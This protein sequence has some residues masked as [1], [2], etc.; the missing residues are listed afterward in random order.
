M[1]RFQLKSFAG[2][3]ADYQNKG[4]LGCYKTGWNLDI[5]KDTDSLSC[6]QDLVEEGS[7]V[8]ADLIRWIIPCTDGNAYGFGGAGKIY[9]RTSAGVWTL[10]YTDA[11]GA[12]TGAAEWFL[13]S[14]KTYLFWATATKINC[15]EIPGNSGWTD[16]NAL[17]GYPK[18]TL[19]SATWHTMAQAVG[20]L[21]IAND[22]FLAMIGYDG[23]Y[24]YQAL[25]IFKKH[26]AKSLLERGN[27]VIVGTS[28]KDSAG[29][30]DL[31]QW[32]T[33]AL[34]WN[35]RKQIA[36]SSVNALIDTDLPLAQVGSD[37]GIFYSDMQ[38]RLPIVSIP[39]GGYCNP[40]G[41]TCKDGLALFGIYGNSL[42]NNRA[43]S[44]LNGIYSYGRTKLN[45]NRVL[46]LEYNIGTCDEI[47]AL[48]KVG[49]DLLVSYQNGSSY[50]VKKV[51]TAVKAIAYY[52]SLDLKAP[53][54]F[55]K[56]PTWTA[57]VLTMK[58]LPA[59]C[60][61]QAYYK[62][63]KA[64]SFITAKM[65]GGSQTFSTTGGKEAIFLLGEK[66]KIVEVGIKLTPNVNDTPEIYT[67]DVYF[68]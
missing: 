43:D 54:D 16:V 60:A 44:V 2:G 59:S 15:K 24:A 8:I 9:K 26:S 51:N 46:T 33:D 57:L 28:S 3:I 42:T 65:E 35:D 56:I 20:S 63:E 27:N 5:R 39:G 29:K 17:A 61:V 66:A 4:L 23:S 37:G 25:N 62:L 53:D 31:V 48:C 38:N 22:D 36:G 21:Q 55:G 32:D 41:V 49:T 18:T 64:G 14:G 68:E 45:Q 34:S 13:S 52:Y 12:I 7:G 47:G 11:D 19:T 10:V 1:N 50:Y 58:S 40:G 67:G 30:T 6:Q